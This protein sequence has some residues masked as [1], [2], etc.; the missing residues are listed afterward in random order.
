MKTGLQNYDVIGS[1]IF[2]YLHQWHQNSDGSSK[3]DTLQHA[4]WLPDTYLRIAAI[5]QGFWYGNRFWPSVGRAQDQL[6]V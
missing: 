5:M 4:N 1:F 3:I 6:R 2:A